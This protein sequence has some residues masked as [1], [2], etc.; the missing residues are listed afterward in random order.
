L[1]VVPAGL[2]E[3]TIAKCEARIQKE[4]RTME[5]LREGK[6]TLEIYGWE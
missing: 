3:E 4:K 6:T 1:V 2:T 5:S